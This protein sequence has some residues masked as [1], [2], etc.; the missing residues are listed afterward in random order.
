MFEYNTDEKKNSFNQNL[1]SAKTTVSTT[2]E[3]TNK[4][5][6]E[7]KGNFGSNNTTNKQTDNSIAA[8]LAK[9]LIKEYKND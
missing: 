7:L 4:V 2:A 3:R 6:L 8:N 9:Q 5:T 1:G